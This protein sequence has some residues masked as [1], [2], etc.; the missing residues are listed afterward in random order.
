MAH[1]TGADRN[2]LLLLPP[3]LDELIGEDN[4]VKVID[5]FVNSLDLQKAGFKN[6]IPAEKGCPPFN[7]ADLLKLYLYGY[8]NRIRSSRKLEKECARNIELI[9]LLNRLQP[10]YRTIAYFRANNTK[11]IKE[12]FRQ[13]IVMIKRW[14]LISGDLL[15][16]DGSKLRAVNSKKNNYNQRKIERHLK[17]IDE[18]VEEYLKELEKNDHEEQGERH[19]KVKECLHQLEKR[20]QKYQELEKHLKNTGEEQVSTTDPESRQLMIRGQITEVAYNAQITVDSKHNLVIDTL[21]INT[22]DRKILSTMG[23]RAK[24]IVGKESIELL[25]DKGYHN[26]EELQK[27]EGMNIRTYVAPQ[28][29]TCGDKIPTE[30]YLGDKFSYNIHD[31]SYTCP[32]GQVLTT[33]GRWF[34]KTYRNHVIPI[35][36]YKTKACREC[37]KRC[38]CT[39]SPIQR[40]RVI[41]RTKYQDSVDANN[42]RVKQETEK[43][44]RRQMMSEHPFGVVKRQW[45]YDHVFMKGLQKVDSE[46]SLI[47]LCY[48]L[49]RVMNIMGFN[50]FLEAIRRFCHDLY[51]LF[52]SE[53][54][55]TY[56]NG[57]IL[58]LYRSV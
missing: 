13:F 16:V 56:K 17:Y 50:G 25:A 48:D 54:D 3:S 35:K 55:N 26:G 8:C 39:K 43:Y 22:N 40:G 46:I 15:S 4:P 2:Q 20:R 57:L 34:K 10:R 32:E 36:Q 27:C 12:I 7:P 38:L 5:V 9:W 24:E 18:K 49:K 21:A 28:E 52:Q 45:G 31:D 41:E 6:S 37:S 53:I 23:S 11:A 42:K 44:R 30:D 29:T 58:L 51:T 33:T 1:R 19:I 14:D 47:F